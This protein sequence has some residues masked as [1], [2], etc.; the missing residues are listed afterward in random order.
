[1]TRFVTY[2]SFVMAVIAGLLTH[3]AVAVAEQPA[4]RGQS[5]NEVGAD[6]SFDE[7]GYPGAGVPGVL[8]SA[9]VLDHLVPSCGPVPVA[10][11]A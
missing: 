1:M 3:A 10:Y 4:G 6:D 5:N 2:H 7:Q 11:A 9:K 8:C